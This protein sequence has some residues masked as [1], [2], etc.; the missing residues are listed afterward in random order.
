MSKAANNNTKKCWILRRYEIIATGAI[1][2]DIRNERGIDYRTCLFPDGRASCTCEART[3][4]YHI[5]HLRQVERERKEK[6]TLQS[7]PRQVEA[8]S[9]RQASSV[10]AALPAWMMRG[11]REGGKMTRVS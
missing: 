4:C 10:E 2:A 5:K 9:E 8:S 1:C 6:A 3:E 11:G 7:E